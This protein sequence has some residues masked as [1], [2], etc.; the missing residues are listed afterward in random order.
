M[1]PYTFRYRAV[2]C[3]DTVQINKKIQYHVRNLNTIDSN[4]ANEILKC[5]FGKKIA[6]YKRDFGRNRY[7]VARKFWAVVIRFI[8]SNK[9]NSDLLYNG[10]LSIIKHYTVLFYD[11]LRFEYECYKD[12]DGKDRDWIN[13]QRGSEEFQKVVDTKAEL[14]QSLINN[15]FGLIEKLKG[16][17]STNPLNNIPISIKERPQP[18]LLSP[19]QVFRIIAPELKVELT[20]NEILWPFRKLSPTELKELEDVLDSIFFHTILDRIA[21]KLIEFDSTYALT[22]S[23]FKVVSDEMEAIQDLTNDSFYNY[24]LVQT[25]YIIETTYRKHDGNTLHS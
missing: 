3:L 13:S 7:P 18:Y 9:Q 2:S 1:I 4:S 12:L 17:F 11:A 15:L 21:Q 14:Y 16:S 5:V 23:P 8:L 24:D 22:F 10:I 25:K 6:P 19:E 20:D